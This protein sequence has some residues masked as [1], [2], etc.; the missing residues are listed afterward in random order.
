MFGATCSGSRFAGQARKLIDRECDVFRLNSPLL[1]IADVFVRFD[2]V[3]S[4]TVNA[5]HSIM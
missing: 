3:A 5:N 2:H 1:K 4:F